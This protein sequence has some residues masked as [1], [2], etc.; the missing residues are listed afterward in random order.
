MYIYIYYKF[1]LGLK[2]REFCGLI[3]EG[4]F[5]KFNLANLS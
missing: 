3:K 2:A 4:I 5:Y 1:I